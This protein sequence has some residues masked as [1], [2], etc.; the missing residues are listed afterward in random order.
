MERTG[1]RRIVLS[2]HDFDGVPGGPPTP[3]ASHARQRRRSREDCRDGHAAERLPHAARDRP[4][5][6]ACRCRSSRWARRAFRRACSPSWMGSCWT[7]AGDGV[8]PG[9][10]APQRMQDEFGFRRIGARTAIYGVLGQPVS[11]SVSPAMHNAAFRADASD[12]VY[13]PL[14]AADFDD[15]LTF[16]DAVGLRRRQR[17]RAV[18]GGRV[19]A[20]RRVRSGQPAHSVGQHA[21]PRRREVARLQHR[22]RRA[23][24]R[25][26]SHRCACAAHAPRC[27]APAARRDRSSVALASAGVRVTIAARRDGQARTVA[28][29]TGAAM[30]ARGRPIRRLGRAGE[31]DAGRHGARVDESP[32]PDGYRFTAASSSTTSS[33]T[34][35]KRDCCATRRAAGCR[36]HRRPR[37]ARRAGAGAV[38]M[39]DRA[40]PRRSRDARRRHRRDCDRRCRTCTEA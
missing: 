30:S 31:R 23:S 26:S 11:H 12:A 2:H 16:A 36:T 20:S 9:Q 28:A 5:R 13:L 6:R 35:R 37:H 29:L 15:F 40:A 1:G 4:Q 33:T 8:A 3:G 24:S 10:I 18:Q 27:S 32:L 38:R 34:R 25:R 17:H 22:R 7:Y 39:V 14:A 19:R 21:A